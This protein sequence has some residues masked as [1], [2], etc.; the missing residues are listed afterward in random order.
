[1]MQIVDGLGSKT[2][3]LVAGVRD[4]DT[5]AD[6]AVYGFDTFSI[7]P[8]LARQLFEVPLSITAAPELNDDIP[9]A[10]RPRNERGILR[11]FLDNAS[12]DE[13]S[14]EALPTTNVHLTTVK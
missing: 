1:M 4:A 2:R 14:G 6:L 5:L 13:V 3:V 8:A 12:M 11:M 9:S 10:V 7:S